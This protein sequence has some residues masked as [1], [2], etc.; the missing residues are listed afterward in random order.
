MTFA[1]VGPWLL[2]VRRLERASRRRSLL[3]LDSPNLV[4][5]EPS[6]LGGT[7]DQLSDLVC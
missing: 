3:C 1:I 4:D 7:E 2:T 5:E 6:A